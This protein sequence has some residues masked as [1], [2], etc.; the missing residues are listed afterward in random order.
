MSL[1]NLF[2]KEN[3]YK[4]SNTTILIV[5]YTPIILFLLQV[6]LLIIPSTRHFGYWLLLENNP[7]ELLTFILFLFAGFFGLFSFKIYKSEKKNIIFFYVIF[8]ICLIILA[9]EEISW[10]QS[11]FNFETPS[12]WKK[13]NLQGETTLHNIKGMQSNTEVLRLIFGAFGLFG[14][15]L[16]NNPRIKKIGT[17][18]F[19]ITWFTII[20]FHAF[21]DLI[22]DYLKFKRFEH[23][24]SKLSELIEMFI[25]CS[26]FLYL[27]LN[28]KMINKQPKCY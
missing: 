25:A 15:F 16:R 10:G 24:V 23:A 6:L 14:I 18:I 12:I 22:E 11:F 20:S 27:W 1:L 17:P 28:F 8:S 19:L 4:I 9:M 21:I 13:I 26:S 7:I 3:N 5:L 2:Y